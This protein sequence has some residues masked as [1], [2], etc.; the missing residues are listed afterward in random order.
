MSLV[1]TYLECLS[2]SWSVIVEPTKERQIKRTLMN[3]EYYKKWRIPVN[4]YTNEWKL[5]N[6]MGISTLDGKGRKAREETVR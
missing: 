5:T 3:T 4:E 1:Q 6:V 2:T